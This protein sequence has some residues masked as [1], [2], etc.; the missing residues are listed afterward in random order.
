MNFNSHSD[1]EGRHAFLSASKGHWVNYTDEKFDLNWYTHKASVRGTQLHDL[2]C[3]MIRLGV[4]LADSPQ[5]LNRYVNDAIGF[6]MSPE[7]VIA[8]SYNAFG[9][10]DALSFNKDP[11]TGRMV[12][13][14]HDLKTGMTKTTFRQLV[15]YVAMFCLEYDVKPS[16]IDVYLRIYQYDDYEEIIPDLDEVIKIMDVLVKWDARIKQLQRE[17]NR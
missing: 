10:A 7:F 15:I 9:T 17:D 14:I 4:K 16:E 6:R 8:Y 3:R 2:A 5:T 12:L 13:R 1:L 11:E